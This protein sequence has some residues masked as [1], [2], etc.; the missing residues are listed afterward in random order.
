MAWNPQGGGPWGGGGGQGPWG[1]GPGGSG[2]RPPDIEDLIRQG[3][4]RFKRFLPGGIGAGKGLIIAII[5]VLTLWL[6]VGGTFKVEP[7]EQG[8]GLLFGKFSARFGPG[9][10][11]FPPSPIGTVYKPQVTLV[12]RV[13]VGFRSGQQGS[14]TTAA[15]AVPQE[16][17]MLTGD[18]NIIDVQS[19]VFWIINDAEKFLFNIR[20]PEQTVKDASE[21][22]LREIIG[23]NEFEFARTQGRAAIEREGKILIQTIL[24]DYGAGIEVNRV[25]LQKIDPPGNVLDAF[26]DVQ[27]ARADKERAVNEATAYLNEN[28]QKAEGEA[29]RIVK[30]AE[31]YKEQKIAISSGESQRFLSVYEQYLNDKSVTKRRLY[32]ETMKSIMEGM[33]K[34][35]IDSNLGGS[36]VVPYLPLNEL[37]RSSGSKAGGQ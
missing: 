21:A 15:R 24:D 26:R 28:V 34:V 9:L 17:L 29:Q 23:K 4:E 7:S 35:L 18:E 13:Q 8:I 10:H 22:A 25:Q 6:G 12:N 36:G 37:T 5:A 1:K 3:Q 19:V 20:N 27:A 32:L 31:A 16:S 14:R 11:W 33:D 2:P 30:G